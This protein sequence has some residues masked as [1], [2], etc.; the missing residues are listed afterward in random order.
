MRSCW[1]FKDTHAHTGKPTTRLENCIRWYKCIRHGT[2]K[3]PMYTEMRFSAVYKRNK[4][5]IC[6]HLLVVFVFSSCRYVCTCYIGLYILIC[7]CH[8]ASDL[9]VVRLLSGSLFSCPGV[10]LAH[11]SSMTDSWH[12]SL[13]FSAFS[14]YLCA[15][16]VCLNNSRITAFSF[17]LTRMLT[18]DYRLSIGLSSNP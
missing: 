11:M 14:F 3:A 6:C 18:W 5:V 8:S 1:E 16:L 12:I 15:L 2:N 4:E 17:S 9:M 13:C 10:C 7:S